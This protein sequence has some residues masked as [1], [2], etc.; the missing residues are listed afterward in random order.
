MMRQGLIGE[1]NVSVLECLRSFD[2]K[3]VA[4]L[5]E[6]CDRRKPTTDEIKWLVEVS[7]SGESKPRV[8]ATWMLK[9]YIEQSVSLS[10]HQVARLLRC[11]NDWEEWEATLHVLQ[12]F[13]AIEIPRKLLSTTWEHCQKLTQHENKMVRAW[14]LHGLAHISQREPEYQSE[15]LLKCR[16]S[17]DDD[18]A[19]VRARARKWVK[20]LEKR[21]KS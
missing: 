2:G 11:W 12:I 13:G 19:A 18:S 15:A 6:Y 9:R 20:I 10:K 17:L 21:P 7:C 16:A 3:K 14:A 1:S 5:A 8:A 4:A